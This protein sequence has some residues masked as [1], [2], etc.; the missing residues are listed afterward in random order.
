[1]INR[2]ISFPNALAMRARSPM[3]I[4]PA[5][6]PIRAPSRR[7]AGSGELPR[8]ANDKPGAGLRIALFSGNYNC[9]RDGANRALNKLVAHLIEQG[10]AVRVYSPTIAEPAFAPAGDLVSGGSVP[11]PGR[12]EFR[13]ALGLPKAVK[14]D[15]RRFGPN[16]IHVSAPDLL[17]TAAQRFA[18]R[19]GV[20]IVA[21]LHTR[22]E[23]YFDYYGLGMLRRWAE[24]RLSRFYRGSD[25]VLAPN[26]SCAQSL[27]EMDVKPGRI[28]LWGRGIDPS[29]FSPALR[30]LGWRRAHGYRDDEI[31]PLFF[32]RLVIEKGIQVFADTIGELRERGHDLRP[33]IVGIGPAERKMRELLP[34]ALFVGHLEGTALGRAIASADILINPSITEAFGNVNLE[35]MASG[36]AVVSADV[37]SAQA[38]IDHGRSGLLVAPT[39]AAFADA[40]EMLI[41]AP[42]LRRAMQRDAASAS[43]EYRWPTIL[44][45]VL[46]RYRNVLT[47]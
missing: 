25:C 43:A 19:I 10:A 37:G 21:S 4:G 18:R 47:D 28:A 27:I 38:L 6:E 8:A 9:V 42:D 34:D 33:L 36:V 45:D 15:I 13:I 16:L 11:I 46:Y 23:T 12:S 22:F 26:Q 3:P 1:M 2:P 32:G 29:A 14:D 17:G 7:L 44:N 41:D 31:V 5:A 40:T 35:A 39:P 24:R 30:N 20:P